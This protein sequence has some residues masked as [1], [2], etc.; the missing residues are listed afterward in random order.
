MSASKKLLFWISGWRLPVLNLIAAFITCGVLMA[1]RNWDFNPKA[2][3]R[4]LDIIARASVV[5]FL[6][7]FY[8]RPLNEVFHSKLTKWMVKNRRYIG[9]SFS[10]W[11]LQHLWILPMWGV[12]L[13]TKFWVNGRLAY[14][15]ISILL[16]CTQTLTSFN[17]AQKSM[18]GWKAIHW[19]TMQV[20]WL[21][22][23]AVY[24]L[25]WQKRGEAY[26][27]VYVALFVAGQVLR[28]V[29]FARKL[30]RDRA[31]EAS[32]ATERQSA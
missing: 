31:S 4:M 18:P 30:L 2:F 14:A 8:A 27:L 9:L 11:F 16:I 15:T 26:Q 6:L 32:L 3:A 25:F 21:W 5:Y 10:A 24:I 13:F 12:P 17:R 28:I 19:I 29:L 23:L 22:F 20:N 7:A 1:N